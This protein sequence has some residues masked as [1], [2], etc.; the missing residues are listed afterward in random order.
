M[1]ICPGCRL[2]R[3]LQAASGVRPELRGER[4]PRNPPPPQGERSRGPRVTTVPVYESSRALATVSSE[5]R[6]LL[7]LGYP[8]WPLAALALLD[9]KRSPVVRRQA[10]QAIGFNFGLFG[11]S[12]GLHA[13]SEIPLLGWSAWPLLAVI[14][15][16]WL[17]A[18][19]VYGFKVW[20]GDDVRVPLVTDWL[21]ER[22][23]RRE[24]KR[25]TA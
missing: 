5:T 23:A 7:A 3:K 21:D 4:G 22:E 10:M 14:F 9:P 18:S 20:N 19:I 16:V 12:L 15:P 24:R 6:G 1:G 13:V 8:V 11:L 17:V 25:A 2:E